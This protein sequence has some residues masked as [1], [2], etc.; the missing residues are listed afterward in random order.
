MRPLLIAGLM[1]L[2]LPAVAECVTKA[3]LATGIAVS[4][5]SGDVTTLTQLPDG[6]I[7]SLEM[8]PSEGWATRTISSMG[9]YHEWMVELSRPS[10]SEVAA[11]W[12]VG[13]DKE[14]PVPAAD[15]APISAKR[16]ITPKGEAS[17]ERPYLLEFA[18]M[19]DFVFGACAYKAVLVKAQIKSIAEVDAEQTWVYFSDLGVAV[20]TGVEAFGSDPWSYLMQPV[21]ITAFSAE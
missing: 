4:F 14:L 13:F 20:L 9:L 3:D 17:Y 18:A 15:A 7:D 10:L 1:A 6:R 16:K 21:A 19:P 12:E 5:D 2:P 11:E 8:Q